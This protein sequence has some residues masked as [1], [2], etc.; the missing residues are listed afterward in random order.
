M[1]VVIV[2]M[3]KKYSQVFIAAHNTEVYTHSLQGHS[4]VARICCEDGKAGK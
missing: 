1:Q 4:G 2:K 3:V